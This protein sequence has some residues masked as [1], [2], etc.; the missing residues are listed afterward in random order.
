M[1]ALVHRASEGR[2]SGSG[3]SH[4][5]LERRKAASMTL[6]LM[7]AETGFQRNDLT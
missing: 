5:F 4:V 6:S 3:P 2:K 1:I 7:D